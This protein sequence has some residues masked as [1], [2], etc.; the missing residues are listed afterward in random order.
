MDNSF[1]QDDTTECWVYIVLTPEKTHK[2]SCTSSPLQ[3]NYTD[4]GQ[5]VWEKKFYGVAN[6][7]A[8]KLLLENLSPNSLKNIIRQIPL[9]RNQKK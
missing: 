1:Y 6:A 3:R 4:E 9:D 7:V 5:L 2:I 8:H